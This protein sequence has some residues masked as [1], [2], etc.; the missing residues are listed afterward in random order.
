MD[1]LPQRHHRCA[2]LG[3]CKSVVVLESF[4]TDRWSI[5][6]TERFTALHHLP[7]VGRP[8]RTHRSTLSSIFLMRIVRATASLDMNISQ[9]QQIGDLWGSEI[10]QSV[11]ESF[12][13]NSSTANAGDINGNRIFYANDYMVS[14]AL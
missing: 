11:A 13:A 8:V 9:I 14:C 10:I 1:G 4:Q 3:L 6:A 2:A 7:R 5:R 12:A